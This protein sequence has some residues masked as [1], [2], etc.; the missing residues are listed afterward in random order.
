MQDKV[1]DKPFPSSKGGGRC[2]WEGGKGWESFFCKDEEANS[3]EWSQHLS[4]ARRLEVCGLG[5]GA[6][7]HLLG[8]QKVDEGEPSRNHATSQICRVLWSRGLVESLHGDKPS[9]GWNEKEVK[10]SCTQ[11]LCLR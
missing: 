7:L 9:M 1:G 5:R 8:F 4:F 10:G 3:E 2:V 6:S 11:I